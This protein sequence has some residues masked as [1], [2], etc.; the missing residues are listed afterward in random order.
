LAA[1]CLNATE[2]VVR[3]FVIVYTVFMLRVFYPISVYRFIKPQHDDY[4]E[5]VPNKDDPVKL[6]PTK[7]DYGKGKQT[8]K[9]L[10]CRYWGYIPRTNRGYRTN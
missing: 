5:Y 8:I 7:G 4:I 6:I 10:H 1:S 9:M 3:D 2:Y